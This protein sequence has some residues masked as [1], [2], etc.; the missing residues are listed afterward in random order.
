MV[1]TCT[2]GMPRR[3]VAAAKPVRSPIMPP[4][5]A[6]SALSRSAPRA[7]SRVVEARDLAQVLAGVAVGDVDARDAWSPRGAQR[8]QRA[9]ARSAVRPAAP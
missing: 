1:G 9:R 5:S 2:N 7:S 8:A 6:T 4:P 3:K